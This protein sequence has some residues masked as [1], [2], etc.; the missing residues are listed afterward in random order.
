MLELKRKET[1]LSFQKLQYIKTT[2]LQLRL[3]TYS[4]SLFIDYC[5]L[6]CNL[7]T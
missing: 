1:R 2:L 5:K 6:A 3:T 7:K 4:V